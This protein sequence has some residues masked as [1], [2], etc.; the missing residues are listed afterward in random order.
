[1]ISNVRRQGVSIHTVLKMT[2]GKGVGKTAATYRYWKIQRGVL[3]V[4]WVIVTTLGGMMAFVVFNGGVILLVD[5][6]VTK[7]VVAVGDQPGGGSVA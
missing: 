2:G 3:V 4:T 6:T 7:V 1:M 5:D